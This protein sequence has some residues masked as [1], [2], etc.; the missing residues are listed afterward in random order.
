MQLR[1]RA[2]FNNPALAQSYGMVT[3]FFEGDRVMR[4]CPQ[5]RQSFPVDH[6]QVWNQLSVEQQRQRA[7][8]ARCSHCHPFP[9]QTP[10]SRS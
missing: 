4:D 8:A 1:F 2:T 10:L 9:S 3:V 6:R 7:L 5:C